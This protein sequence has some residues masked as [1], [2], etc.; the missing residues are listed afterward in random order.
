[1]TKQSTE[2]GGTD[3]LTRKW[4][5]AAGAA[6]RAE[7]HWPADCLME[8]VEVLETVREQRHDLRET[9]DAEREAHIEACPKVWDEAVKAVWMRLY[10]SCS[11]GDERG[12]PW[13]PWMKDLLRNLRDQP[14]PNPY[15]EQVTRPGN[16]DGSSA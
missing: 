5:A 14:V 1:M 6:R 3:D 7:H 9:L 16:S 11:H 8:A 10:D 4:I 12:E 2:N 15:A 13:V